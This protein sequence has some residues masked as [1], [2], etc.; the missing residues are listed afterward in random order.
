MLTSGAGGDSHSPNLNSPA[1]RSKK[2]KKKKGKKG[3]E[4]DEEDE[5]LEKVSMEEMIASP[6]GLSLVHIWDILSGLG[7]LS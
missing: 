2:G 6:P 1:L 4:E 7:F 5:E 3:G